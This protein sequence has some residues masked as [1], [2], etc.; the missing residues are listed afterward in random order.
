MSAYDEYLDEPEESGDFPFPPVVS[1]APAVVE[2][3]PAI[4]ESPAAESHGVL[5]QIKAD[6]IETKMKDCRMA[7]VRMPVSLYNAI[8]SEA[9]ARGISLNALCIDALLTVVPNR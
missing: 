4:A 7:T 2:S 6:L 3:T 5:Q 1:A 8:Q 9:N